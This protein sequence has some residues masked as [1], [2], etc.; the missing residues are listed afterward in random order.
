MRVISKKPLREFWQRHPQSRASLEEWF[1]KASAM[2]A[3]SFAQLRATFASADY[4][5]GFTIFDIGGNRYRIA[6][7][8]WCTTTANACMSGR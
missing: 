7:P 3:D 1:R 4:V 2:R 6:S 8:P 5:D